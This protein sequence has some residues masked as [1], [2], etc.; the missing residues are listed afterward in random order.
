MCRWP[1]S[2]PSFYSRVIAE[3]AEK[4]AVIMTTNLPFA[5]WTQVIPNARLCKALLDRITIE[6]TS[7]KPE[8]SRIA[9]GGRRT[10]RR[11]E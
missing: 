1:K 9:F 3:R 8:R 2:E 4:T 7:W 5:E 6:R 10:D 11:K